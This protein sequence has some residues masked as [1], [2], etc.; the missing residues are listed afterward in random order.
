[1]AQGKYEQFVIYFWKVCL[2][3]KYVFN[4]WNSKKITHRSLTIGLMGWNITAC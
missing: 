3:W 4:R 1:M 2:Q